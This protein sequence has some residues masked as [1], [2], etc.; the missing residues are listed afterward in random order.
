M[1]GGNPLFN[2]EAA[3]LKPKPGL[4][5]PPDHPTKAGLS[6]APH[7]SDWNEGE[8]APGESQDLLLSKIG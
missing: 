3:P 8:Q 5:G 6:G 1:G 4:S 7:R 2:H